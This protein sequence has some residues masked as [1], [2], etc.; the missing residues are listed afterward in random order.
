MQEVLN[1]NFSFK[2]LFVPLTTAKAITII[3]ILGFIV[4]GN[5]L[6]NNFVWD[7]NFILNLSTFKTLNF[8]YLFGVNDI[9][10]F[11]YYRP[12][13][14]V[15][16]SILIH[17]FHTSS[18]FYHI[19]QLFLHISVV[20]LL[21][22][23][24]CDFFKRTLSL[25]LSLFFLIHPINA[26]S[27]SYISASPSLLFTLLGL[28]AL[29]LNRRN[30]VDNRKFLFIFILLL[31][32]PLVKEIGILFLVM[33]LLYEYLFKKSNTKK[34]VLAGLITSGIYLYL[35]IIFAQIYISDHGHNM[36]ITRLPFGWRF[37]NIPSTVFYYLKT[38][39]LPLQ[40]SV[41]Q[42]WVVKS[43]SFS[44]FYLPLLIEIIL[45][46]ALA[47]LGFNLHKRNKREWSIFLFFRHGFS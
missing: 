39:I 33:L 19:V 46:V 10:S 14:A 6:F 32:S 41:M 44:E 12:L 15:Y 3:I 9:N 8:F 16:F 20:C 25:I 36:A 40:L 45:I 28:F 11:G 22:L 38:T 7:D 2:K 26:E 17:L 4:Y 5:M 31:L 27:V 37:A 29:L 21:Y 43:I 47:L 34:Y 13:S 18:F 24:F 35:R 1:V 30:L 23:F 42:D